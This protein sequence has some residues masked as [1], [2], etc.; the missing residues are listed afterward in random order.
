[1]AGWDR[2]SPPEIRAGSDNFVQISNVSHNTSTRTTS[3]RVT[4]VRDAIGIAYLYDDNSKDDNVLRTTV[5][6]VTNHG[7]FEHDLI[8]S[9]LGRSED[10]LKLHVY[11]RIVNTKNNNTAIDW[12][13]W[14][15][16]LADQPLKQVTDPSHPNKW[17]CGA[18]LN[19]FGTSYF[20]PAH[21]KNGI[22]RLYKPFSSKN[23]PYQKSDIVF[24]ADLVQ[25]SVGKIKN[26]LSQRTA[27]TVFVVH[28]D[29]F[30]ASGGIIHES[31]KTHYL[32]IVGCN[33]SATLF[34]Y[35]DPWPGGS[36]LMYSSGI[37]GNIDSAF[38]G[39][40]KFDSNANS[41]F[42]P[43]GFRGAHDYLVLTGP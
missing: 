5:G 3:F 39:L 37:F 12:K 10:A 23:R 20:G 41:I 2:T 28:H 15:R 22:T 8:A 24:D 18:A 25:R 29:G 11:D 33:A 30:S 27:V 17:N 38:M 35:T 43:A 13:D 34:L 14:D 7:D 16:L 9:E 42:S 40:L 31:A 4:P 32:T 36:K 26:L 21:Y 19:Q 1:M 6:K